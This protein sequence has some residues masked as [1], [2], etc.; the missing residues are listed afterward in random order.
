MKINDLKTSS[1]CSGLFKVLQLTTH[2]C[3]GI[4]IKREDS[5]HLKSPEQSEEVFKSLRCDL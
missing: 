5:Q 4:E 1:L 2:T 3:V